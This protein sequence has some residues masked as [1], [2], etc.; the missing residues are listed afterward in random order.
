M[1]S[2]PIIIIII[3]II[4]IC[5]LLCKAGREWEH[6]QSKD[7]ASHNQPMEGKQR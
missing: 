3:I 4:I 2:L 5:S 6:Y 7:P 1:V